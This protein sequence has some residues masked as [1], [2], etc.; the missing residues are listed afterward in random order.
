M[1]ECM[2]LWA[3]VYYLKFKVGVTFQKFSWCE[4]SVILHNKMC[5]VGL[6]TDD[7]IV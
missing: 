7:V 2:T 5:L 4:I 1:Y 6:W 3:L